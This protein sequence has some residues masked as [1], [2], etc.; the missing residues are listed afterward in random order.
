MNRKFFPIVIPI[1]IFVAAAQGVFAAEPVNLIA[2]DADDLEIRVASDR[3]SFEREGAAVSVDI[4]PGDTSPAL[5]L[6]PAMGLSWDLSNYNNIGTLITN[7]SDEEITLHI[8][9]DNRGPHSEKPWNTE[10]AKIGVGESAL[11]SVIFGLHYGHRPGY[12][13]DPSDISGIVIFPRETDMPIRYRVESVL[14]SDE[15]DAVPAD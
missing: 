1:S 13:L 7:E 4:S 3:V 11:I 14:A 8:R 5:Y 6:R 2:P 10:S 12:P 9:V 15:P